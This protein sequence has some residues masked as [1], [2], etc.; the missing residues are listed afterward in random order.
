M[1]DLHCHILA[2]I[3]DG[4]QSMEESLEMARAAVREG[5][6][7]IIATPH[8]K[9][10]RYE[11]TKQAI[12]VK[13]AELNE[14]LIA[15]NIPLKILTGQETAIHGELLKGITLGEVS[16]LNNTQYIFIELP[17]GHVPRYTEKL[18]YDLQV[19]G[20]IPVIVHPER[21]QE[22]IERPEILYQLIKKGALS[23]LTASSIC[24]IFGKKIKGFSEH[25]IEANLVHFIASDAHNTN[26]RGFQMA[27]A[28]DHIN[29]R[30]GVDMVY[31]FKENAELL[32]HDHN[33]YKEVPQRVRK[34]KFLGLF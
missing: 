11:N 30:Y 16:T 27:Q 25:L 1:I 14:V 2:G 4:A 3:D 7:T 10:G 22:I 31:L 23:Q 6:D 29:T 13:T 12:N 26:K 32:V 18:F 21:N 8:H 33:V 24:G 28:Y 19:E 17:V 20:K 9:N 5:I 15:E 34:K